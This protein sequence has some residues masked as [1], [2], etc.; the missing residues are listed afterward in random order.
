MSEIVPDR[1]RGLL[2]H[3]PRFCESNRVLTTTEAA[4]AR[5]NSA[6]TSMSQYA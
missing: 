6:S 4:P 3:D 5:A 2:L 1:I